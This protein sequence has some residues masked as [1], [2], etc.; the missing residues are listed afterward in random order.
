[1][2]TQLASR[3]RRLEARL[4]RM[5]STLIVVVAYVDPDGTEHG[6]TQ[7]RYHAADRS[8][9]ERSDDGGCTWYRAPSVDRIETS[10]T[11]QFVR[12][13]SRLCCVE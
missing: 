5:D 3:V 11:M 13:A 8:A 7:F 9:P 12:D 6:T 2:T 10:G 1:M 4:A